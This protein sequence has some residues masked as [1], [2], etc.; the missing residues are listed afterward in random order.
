MYDQ[1]TQLN[2]DIDGIKNDCFLRQS[3]Y[4]KYASNNVFLNI[5]GILT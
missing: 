2:V 4:K 1:G 5:K 3:N